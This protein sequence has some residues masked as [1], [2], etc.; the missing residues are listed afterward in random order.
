[1]LHLD[2]GHGYELLGAQLHATVQEL[3]KMYGGR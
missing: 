2:A 3:R 1:M